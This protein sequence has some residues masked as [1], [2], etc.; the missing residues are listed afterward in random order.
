M[1]QTLIHVTVLLRM[2]CNIKDHKPQMHYV[3][4]AY[5]KPCSDL[6]RGH[7]SY[8]CHICVTQLMGEDT[9]TTHLDCVVM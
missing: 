5:T 3:T 6:K 2:S 8:S 7:S 4:V 1:D 9:L